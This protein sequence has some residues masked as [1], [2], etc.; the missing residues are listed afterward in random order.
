M[1][2]FLLLGAV[3][4][5]LLI[6]CIFVDDHL[7]GIFDALGGGDWFTGAGLAGFLGALG[8]G[9]AAAYGLTGSVGLALAAGSGLGLLLGLAMGWVM[10]QMRRT[11]DGGAPTSEGLVGL[12]G[13]VVSDI[14][15]EGYGEVRLVQSGHLVKLNARAD[16]AVPTGAPVRVTEVL[17]ATAVRVDPLF[18]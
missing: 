16:Q 17:S 8:F 15:T 1:T 5:I 14:P 4:A 6:V 13:A 9:G 18:R 10:L 7:G 3:G 2:V 11:Q 12:E